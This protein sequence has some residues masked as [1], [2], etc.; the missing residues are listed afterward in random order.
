[1]SRED[2]KTIWNRLAMLSPYLV[3]EEYRRTYK[4]C[5]LDGE[6]LPP[7]RT[8]QEFVTVWK[9]MRHGRR[10]DQSH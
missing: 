6:R 4:E 1:L 7:P 2:L 10:R 8:I 5:C 3:K 9:F